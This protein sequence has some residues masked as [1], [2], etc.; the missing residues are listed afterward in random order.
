M[1]QNK[2]D[3]PYIGVFKTQSGE[4]FI[5]KVVEETMIALTVKMPLCMIPTEQ[6]MRFAPF[7][8]MADPEKSLTIP[9]PIISGLPAP[10]LEEQYEQATSSIALPRR[11]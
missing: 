4:E 6:G 9:K 2:K 11:L 5:A 10:K 7:L 8:M 1:L 3:T